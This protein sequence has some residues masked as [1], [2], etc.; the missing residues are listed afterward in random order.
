MAATSRSR[1]SENSSNLPVE[2]SAQGVPEAEMPVS[3]KHA[4]NAKKRRVDAG[5]PHQEEATGKVAVI[6]M[7]FCFVLGVAC[8]SCGIMGIWASHS[9]SSSVVYFARLGSAYVP[10]LRATAAV[11]LV[12]GAILVRRGWRRS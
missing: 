11:C 10:V 6:A 2:N 4:V 9:Q 12:L 8:V 1:E 5:G 7:W 3:H